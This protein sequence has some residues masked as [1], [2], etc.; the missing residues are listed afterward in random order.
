M[1]EMLSP[2]AAIQGAGIKAAL[3]T[4][5]RFSGGTRGLCIGHISPEAASQGPIA[6]IHEGDMIR[7]DAHQKTMELLISTAEIETR[8]KQLQEFKPKVQ[9]GW[10]ARYLQHVRSADKG[11]T[12]DI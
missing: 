8:L 3:I 12:L 5:G 9:R 10:L 2:T 11:A 1:Q 6:A 4:D 7:I